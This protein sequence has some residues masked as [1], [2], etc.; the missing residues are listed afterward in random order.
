MTTNEGAAGIVGATAQ[1][2]AAICKA[3]IKALKKSLVVLEIE[4]MGSIDP[5]KIDITELAKLR[6]EDEINYRSTI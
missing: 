4:H 1:L 5:L 3:S 2:E 6:V